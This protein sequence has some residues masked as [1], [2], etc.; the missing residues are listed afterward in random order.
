[1]SLKELKN[2]RNTKFRDLLNICVD[3]FGDYRIKGDHYIFSMPWE[4]DPYLNLQPDKNNKKMAKPYQVKLAL[5]AL[6]KLK[7]GIYGN[8]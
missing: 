2:L 8:D 6:Q 4:G 1:M 7:E 5:R 3:H